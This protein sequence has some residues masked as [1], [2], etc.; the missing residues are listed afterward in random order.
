MPATDRPSEL[1]RQGVSGIQRFQRLAAGYS[2]R[3][4]PLRNAAELLADIGQ[5]VTVTVKGKLSGGYVR[6]AW[7]GVL[8]GAWLLSCGAAERVR[9]RSPSHIALPSPSIPFRGL[10]ISRGN[11]RNS[12]V[13]HFDRVLGYLPGEIHGILRQFWHGSELAAG[14][15]SA[16]YVA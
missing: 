1:R 5:W 12:W 2:W 10:T 14:G 4:Q 11:A 7:E 15:A 6:W 8:R 3:A 16:E 13:Y 9:V